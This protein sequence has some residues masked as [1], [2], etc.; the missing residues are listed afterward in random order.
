MEPRLSLI[1]SRLERTEKVIQDQ[2]QFEDRLSED[3]IATGGRD[4]WNALSSYCMRYN[5]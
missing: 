4:L 1:E 3:S 5:L 2:Q